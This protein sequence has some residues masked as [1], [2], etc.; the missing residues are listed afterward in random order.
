MVPLVCVER[1]SVPVTPVL[2]GKPVQFVSVPL[3]GVPSTG[4]VNVGLV[5]VGPLESTTEPEPVDVVVPVPPLATG[6]VLNDKLMLPAPF[7]TLIGDV[8]EI[9]ASV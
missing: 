1:L 4:V 6:T 7:D 3:E 2:S 9:V 5:K 8:A